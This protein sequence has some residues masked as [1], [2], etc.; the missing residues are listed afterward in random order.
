M[1]YGEDSIIYPENLEWGIH[2]NHG[3]GGEVWGN[4]LQAL[5]E[6]PPL[7]FKD[8]T[9]VS[10]DTVFNPDTTHPWTWKEPN[11]NNIHPIPIKKVPNTADPKRKL[12]MRLVNNFEDRE[13]SIDTDEEKE[14]PVLEEEEE[15]GFSLFD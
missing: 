2:L 4:L 9:K 3:G 11:W 12:I 10:F 1:P 15:G 6:D 8:K 7:F 13:E 14:Q 5:F